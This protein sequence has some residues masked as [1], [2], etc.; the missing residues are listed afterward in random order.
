MAAT[1]RHW[2][3]AK[4]PAQA[5][6]FLNTSI[7]SKAIR[8]TVSMGPI[9]SWQESNLPL[10]VTV[11]SGDLAAIASRFNQEGVTNQKAVSQLDCNFPST[12]AGV[13]RSLYPASV[14]VAP[15]IVPRLRPHAA[16]IATAGFKRRR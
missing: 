8:M 15:P 1:A 11:I 7:L 12:L 6:R 9:N 2:T 13:P 4:L 10:L 16:A 3:S 14:T 5:F